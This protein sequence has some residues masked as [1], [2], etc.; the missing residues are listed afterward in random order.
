MLIY[1]EEVSTVLELIVFDLILQSD[2]EQ[3]PEQP[4][5]DA[6]ADLQEDQEE[7]VKES[8]LE[9]DPDP[10]TERAHKKIRTL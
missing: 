2:R 3:A 4:P 6:S 1:S 10:E 5:A 9:V 7:E 8:D